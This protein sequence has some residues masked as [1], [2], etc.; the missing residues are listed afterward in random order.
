[1]SGLERLPPVEDPEEGMAT[2]GPQG[3]VELEQVEC[4]GANPESRP[5]VLEGMIEREKGG[6]AD[7]A[8]NQR[9]PK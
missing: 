6:E 8:S 7:G 4:A 1:M 5:S 2:I 9:P 3:S